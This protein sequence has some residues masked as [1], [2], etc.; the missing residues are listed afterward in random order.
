MPTA[1]EQSLPLHEWSA[2]ALVD[3]YRCRALSPV[4]VTQSAL[5]HIERWEPHIQANYLLRPEQ[6][7]E[8]ARAS[9]TRWLRKSPLSALDGVPLTLKDNIAT[10]GDP[11]PL[12]TRASDQTPASLD[13]PPAARLREAGCVLLCKTTMPDYGMLSSGV[14]SFH[15]L[16]RNPWDLTKTPG[17][18]SA[19]AAAAAAAGYAPLHVGTDIGGSLR[20]PASWCG[21]FSLKPSLGRIPIDPAYT[22]RAAGPMTRTVADA[23]L[24]MQAL[25]WPDER[26]SMSLPF[27][28]IDWNN[29]DTP[30]SH[31]D[32]VRIG[33]LLDAGCGLPVDAEVQSAVLRAAQLFE[34]AGAIVTPMQTFLTRAMLDGMD[35]AWR[36]RSHLDLAAL[37]EQRRALVLP[38]IRAWADSVADFSGTEMFTAMSQFHA[39]RVATVK[40]CNAFDYVI[41]PTAPIAAFAA[42]LP[43]PTNDPLRPLDHI[44]FTVPFNMSE[45]PAA[46]IHCGFTLAGLPLGLQI[47]GRRFDD[48]GV[49]Q[50]SR[51]FE[52]LRGPQRPWPEPPEVAQA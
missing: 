43:S 33:L 17:G 21:I 32:G 36:M 12:G 6:A 29:W 50:L 22:G 16:A 40:A 10:R 44:A 42:E 28:A 48:L 5:R 26:D 18:S 39:T 3:A 41:S 23:T 19:G 34:G 24:L 14:S 8:N 35:H 31:L 27:E 2:A 47:A 52:I 45:Q 46:S 9:E 49:L 51:A 15:P 1:T 20:L 38:Y 25:A 13:S 30:I 7:L 11:K 37:P 4:E